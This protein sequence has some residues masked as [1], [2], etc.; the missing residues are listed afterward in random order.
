M[1]DSANKLA[2]ISIVTGTNSSAGFPCPCAHVTYA[3]DKPRLSKP[4]MYPKLQPQPD[5]FPS[6]LLCASS[7]K[8]AEMRFPPQVKKKLESTIST[9]ASHR[10]PGPTK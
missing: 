5:T 10:S 7:G 2:V 1:L 8:K 4:P 9:T 3:S 6:A